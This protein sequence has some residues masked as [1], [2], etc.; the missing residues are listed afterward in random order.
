MPNF[1]S[2]NEFESQ[3]TYEGSDLGATW[4]AEKTSFRLW[5]PTAKSVKVNLYRSGTA[6]TNDLIEQIEMTAD[7]NGTWVAVKE[8]D[9]N[10]VYYTYSVEVGG[11]VVEA[12]DP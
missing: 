9:Q 2:T 3:Y 8:G 1:Y 5:A 6:G 12:C 7:V 4:T 11:E 10:G